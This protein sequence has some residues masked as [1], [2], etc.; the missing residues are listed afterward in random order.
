[1]RARLEIDL[2]G[3]ADNWRDLD[4]MSAANV[5]TAAVVKANAYGLGAPEVVEALLGAGAR[6]FFVALAEEGLALGELHDDCRVF[7][8]SGY[9]EGDRD[10]IADNNL[11]PVLCSPDQVRRF[12]DDLPDH[13][14]ALQLDTGMNRLGIPDSWF[15][16]HRR[17]LLE[18]RPELIVSH[19]ACADEP[20]NS[21]NRRQLERFG[22]ATQ[23][24][25]VSRSLAATGGILL[26][27]DYHFELCRPGIGIYGCL[28]FVAG[29]SVVNLNLPVVQ[30]M[31]ISPGDSVGYGATW[32]ASDRRRIAT[33]LSGYADGIFRHLGNTSCLYSGPVPCPVLGRISMDLITVDVSGLQAEPDYLQLLGPNQSVD[34]LAEN[35]STIGYE[36]LTR[37]GRRYDRVYKFASGRTRIE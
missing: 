37:L 35:A 20:D 31:E 36:V 28:P 18:A 22:V 7:V 21:M 11:V 24:V 15:I 2:S 29:R 23:G 16:S 27:S 32:R 17:Q 4:G 30:V 12:F 9:L 14:F 3:L 13:R 5:E 8:F 1:M 26:G 33:V 6:T 19:L 10:L 25:G 34:S